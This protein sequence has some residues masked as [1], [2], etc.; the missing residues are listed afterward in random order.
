MRCQANVN[1]P[2]FGQKT[3]WCNIVIRMV[4]RMLTLTV[5]LV[6]CN[7]NLF[8]FLILESRFTVSW[9]YWCIPNRRYAER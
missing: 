3:G 7:L 2:E 9:N 4:A 8:V 5:Q 1:I 6:N